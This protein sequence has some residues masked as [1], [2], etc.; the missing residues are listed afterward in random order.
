MEQADT[1]ISR[2]RGQVMVKIKWSGGDIQ[3]LRPEWSIDKCNEFIDSNSDI[4]KE[5]SIS[6]GWDIWSSL[7]EREGE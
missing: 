6:H 2:E 1:T 3:S 7:L 4:F 5:L